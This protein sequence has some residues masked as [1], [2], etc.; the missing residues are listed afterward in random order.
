MEDE[1]ITELFKREGQYNLRAFL[2]A[3]EDIRDSKIEWLQ[4]HLDDK[5]TQYTIAQTRKI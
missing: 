4:S 1:K 3:P 2:E 5:D